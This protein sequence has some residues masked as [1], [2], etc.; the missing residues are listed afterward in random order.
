VYVFV[1]FS[2]GFV[3]REYKNWLRVEAVPMTERAGGKLVALNSV[4]NIKMRIKKSE[5]GNR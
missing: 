1:V 3:K 4:V 5:L 2:A